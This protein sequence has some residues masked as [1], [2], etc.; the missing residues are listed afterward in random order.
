MIHGAGSDLLGE[1]ALE[2]MQHRRP[3]LIYSKVPGRG[4]TPFNCTRWECARD[5]GVDDGRARSDV[6]CVGC[7]LCTHRL[8]AW[9]GACEART[10][11]LLA[12]HIGS[13]QEIAMN[14]VALDAP[15]QA[16]TRMCNNTC[17]NNFKRKPP[18]FHDRK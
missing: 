14:S 1:D 6:N 4:H 10:L 9:D 17:K 16:I 11:R 15:S 5:Q 7:V 8:K 13:R 3:E 12:V 2:G 18:V